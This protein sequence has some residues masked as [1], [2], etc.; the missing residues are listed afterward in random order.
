MGCTTSR[1]LPDALGSTQTN[2]PISTSTSKYNTAPTTTSPIIVTLPIE[3]LTSVYDTAP[4]TAPPPIVTLTTPPPPYQPTTSAPTFDAM[5]PVVV[6]PPLHL[7]PMLS[8]KHPNRKANVKNTFAFQP[9]ACASI[10]HFAKGE[11]QDC[12]EKYISCRFAH[13]PGWIHCFPHSCPHPQT[14]L[15]VDA[16]S[17]STVLANK[18]LTRHQIPSSLPCNGLEYIGL[19]PPGATRWFAIA[20]CVLCG[21]EGLP[22]KTCLYAE[23]T[24]D[25]KKATPQSMPWALHYELD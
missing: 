21:K 9:V 22:V 8:C 13:S 12:K 14:A 11:C 24:N 25:P 15:Q 23:Y 16:T 7:A 5:R 17:M 4:K 20:S 3:T 18:P 2:N 1:C 10:V 19:A 6:T